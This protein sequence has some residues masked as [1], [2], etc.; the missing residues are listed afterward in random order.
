M[1]VS[2][3]APLHPSRRPCRTLPTAGLALAA[4]TLAGC[5][6]D[7]STTTSTGA[8]APR[9]TSNVASTH[10]VTV[11][12]CGME[13]TVDSPPQQTV[14]MNQ[15]ATEIMLALGLEDHM[16]GTAYL[17]DQIL[18]E[19]A[20]AY[21]QIPVLSDEYP[22][23]EALLDIEPDAVY[24]AYPSAFAP[25]SAGERTELADL[26]I[27]TYLSPSACPDKSTAQ[28]LDIETVWQEIRDIG[29]IFGANDAAETLVEEQ[30]AQLDEAV[31]SAGDL[32]GSS[33]LWW[34]H[35]TDAPSIGACCG[36]PA[37]I[38]DAA[39][40]E[41]VFAD[42]TGSWA[43][44]SWEQVTKRDPDVV[45]LVDAAWSRAADK[46]DAI[47]ST[48]GVRDLPAVRED[49]FVTMPFSATTPGVRNVDAVV[50]LITEVEAQR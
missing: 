43:D 38:M 13:V 15:A 46:R 6:G 2:A 23:Q 3:R 30:Q 44:V 33:V 29:T 47:E 20:D 36:A 31:E 37:M 35:G 8:G 12:N 10:P 28:P 16:A 32:S 34:D 49:R 7:D 39:S 22:S 27:I 1:A 11:D 9:P 41:N 42:I 45:V 25:E 26:G 5:S 19:Y 18:P 40:V 21:A 4:L 48:P 14:T 50:D 24:G 17:D